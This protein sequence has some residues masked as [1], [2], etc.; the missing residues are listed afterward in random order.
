MI[1][2][3]VRQMLTAQ[4]FSALTVS[5]C[6]LIDSVMISRFLGEEGI[7]AYGLA[8]PLLL[9]VGAIGSLL[10]AGIQVVCSRSLG[11]GSQEETNAGYSSAV[12]VAGAVSLA[13][14][15]GSLLFQSFF[16]RVMG[17]GSS[18]S[19]FEQT[20][21]YIAGFGI[22]APGS[23]GALV[24]VPVLQMAG[25]NRLLIAAV[26]TMTVAD[27]GLDLLNVLVFHGGMF[28]MGLASAISYYA[29]LAVTAIYFFSSDCVFRVNLK[30][31]TREKIL[32]LLNGGVPAGFSMAAAVV[33]IFLINRILMALGA[34][35]DAQSLLA[36]F[37]VMVS[38][39]N[40]AQCINTGIGGVSL[41]LSGIFYNEEDYSGLKELIRLLCRH[42]VFLGLGMG[43]A[44][45]VFA[46]AFVS[47]FIPESGEAHNLAVLGMRI[48]AA[49]LIPCCINS[50]LKNMY[51]GTGRPALT[52]VIAVLEGAVLPVAAAFIFSR[53]LGATGAWLF[54]AAGEA[55]ALLLIGL[56]IRHRTGKMPWQDGAALLQEDFGAAPEDLMEVSIRSMEE[57][58]AAAEK[59]GQFCLQHRQ[60][61][62]IGNHIA[63]CVE[64]MAGNTVRHGFGK[65]GK[66][67]HLSVRI[68]HKKDHWILR[69]RDDCGAF[70]PVHYIPPEGSETV[71]IHLV[72]ALAEE[73]RY[74]NSLNLNNL[75]LKLPDSSPAAGGNGEE[76]GGNP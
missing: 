15:A 75:L 12:V 40:A 62:R 21:D 4:I 66:D 48:Y 49:G 54:F 74:T 65:D 33:M 55:A 11:K 64:E 8:N 43:A 39:G 68:L 67:H 32:E 16:A 60:S 51:Q 14:A 56:Y 2:K 76:P 1:R 61:S 47:L 34:G 45:A 9:A 31:V 23:M 53:F 30:K 59:A 46:P 42:A 18:G 29:A 26:L 70:D 57:V 73:A 58:A 69:F 19:L 25:Q 38:I 37:T 5:L 10:A 17:A 6:L 3:I 41:T 13:F 35:G 24:L 52:E 71:G 28:G 7:A 22:G 20:R 50:A 63:L 44:L 36:A 27:I 72:L